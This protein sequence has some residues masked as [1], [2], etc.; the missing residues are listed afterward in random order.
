MLKPIVAY[1]ALLTTVSMFFLS[2]GQSYKDI[3]SVNGRR[4]IIET[5]NSFLSSGQCQR[6]IEV[7]SPLYN[8]IYVDLEIRMVYASAHACAGG[9]NFVTLAAAL[10]GSGNL[11]AKLV[12]GNYSA[13]NIDQKTTNLQAAAQ[14]LRS[15]T[16][17]PGSLAAV[18]RPSEANVY[19]LFLQ[20]EIIS[21]TI[22]TTAMGNGDPITGAKGNAITGLG[23]NTDKCNIVVAMATISN[24]S[25]VVSVGS[26]IDAVTAACGGAC[27]T[28]LNPAVCTAVEQAQGDAL[29]IA[30]D[31]LWQ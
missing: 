11:F 20:L 28:N 21:T 16:T 6:A 9:F 13:S 19:M 12:A 14:I 30:L 15:T 3:S 5:A 26:A 18:D 24:C 7:M 17:N 23:T 1:L 25:S 10:A 4:A 31:G 27:P 22:S 29:I 2:C 8:S